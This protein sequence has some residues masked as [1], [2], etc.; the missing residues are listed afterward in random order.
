MT[1]SMRVSRT[2]VAIS[3]ALLL[4]VPLTLTAQTGELEATIRAAILSD[5][6]TATMSE[7]EID[8]MVAA[9]AQ[10]AATQGVTSQ[11]IQWRPQEER[12]FMSETGVGSCN[13]L[14]KLT[15]AFGFDGSDVTIPIA[16]GICA[17]LLIF[18]I[19]SLLHREYGRHPVAGPLQAGV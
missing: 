19:G 7:A 17:G 2:A 5:P 11:D 18:L 14:C 15:N 1:T 3:L 12:G 6:R 4:L 9:L 16:L 10:E 13:M 8:A